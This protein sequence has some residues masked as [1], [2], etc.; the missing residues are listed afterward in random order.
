VIALA[1]APSDH[2]EL[3]RWPQFPG[4]EAV[5]HQRLAMVDGDLIT[6]MGPRFPQGARQ[7]CAAIDRAR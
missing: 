1:G 6:R 3:A 7:L 5:K 2:P 4:V